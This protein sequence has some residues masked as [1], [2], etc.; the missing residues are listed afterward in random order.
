MLRRRGHLLWR[1][2]LSVAPQVAARDDRGP[3]TRASRQAGES[4]RRIYALSAWKEGPLFSMRER[5][6]LALTEA[7][8][9]I[10]GGVSDEPLEQA[11][12]QFRDEELP[13]L[14]YAII[15][16]NAFNRLAMTARTPLERIDDPTVDERCK[17]NAN[18]LNGSDGS[19]Q[20]GFGVANRIMPRLR[21]MPRCLRHPGSQKSATRKSPSR[22]KAFRCE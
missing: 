2:R 18:V 5:V 4:E 1:L 15:E 6:A 16:V 7:V 9:R 19:R 11:E 8:T 10:G 22:W 3:A 17:L 13:V 20:G 14:L 21:P 12:E